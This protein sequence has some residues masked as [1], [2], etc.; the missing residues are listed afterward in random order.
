MEGNGSTPHK[1]YRKQ[2]QQVIKLKFL[3]PYYII[4]LTYDCNKGRRC[5]TK[6]HGHF[7]FD[8]LYI[9]SCVRT[10][11]C[12]YIKDILSIYS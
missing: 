9:V 10:L 11:D 4:E 3:M 5:K 1:M 12:Q 7:Q 2:I 6:G 8:K